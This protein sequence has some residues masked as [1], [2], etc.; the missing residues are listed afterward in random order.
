[1]PRYLIKHYFWVCLPGCFFWDGHWKS[2][3]QESKCP[4]PMWRPPPIL[5][6]A[7]KEKKSKGW[8]SSFFFLPHYLIWDISFEPIPHKKSLFIFYLLFLWKTQISSTCSQKWGRGGASSEEQSRQPHPLLFLICAMSGLHSKPAWICS[9]KIW[10][11]ND[12]FKNSR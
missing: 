10:Q 9:M 6:K 8:Y 1:M 3:T 7:Q 11:S 5:E 4:S 12:W 2:C